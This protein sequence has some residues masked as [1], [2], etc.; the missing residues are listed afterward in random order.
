MAK[1]DFV[2]VNFPVVNTGE[3]FRL[4]IC[5]KCPSD[6]IMGTHC[7]WYAALSQKKHTSILKINNMRHFVRNCRHNNNNILYL[8][9]FLEGNKGQWTLCLSR[10]GD[11]SFTSRASHKE[12]KLLQKMWMNNFSRTLF[13][14][15]WQKLSLTE[16]NIKLKSQLKVNIIILAWYW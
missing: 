5:R 14:F 4:R 12:E 1:L 11:C 6:Y 15:F 2:L 10:E 13:F 16:E 9:L 7:Q 8:H 3:F